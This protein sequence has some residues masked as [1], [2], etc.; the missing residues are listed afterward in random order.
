MDASGCGSPSRIDVSVFRGSRAWRRNPTFDVIFSIARALKV[1]VADLVDV[2]N[3]RRVELD[4]LKL[5]PPK[6]DASRAARDSRVRRRKRSRSRNLYVEA[7]S[8][9]CAH[10]EIARED[11]CGKMIYTLGCIDLH[12]LRVVFSRHEEVSCTTS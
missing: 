12:A 10:R 11:H 2:E 9:R 8:I 5:E 1:T 4:R 7:K 3:D 6:T